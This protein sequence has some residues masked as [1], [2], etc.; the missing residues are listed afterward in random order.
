MAPSSVQMLDEVYSYARL[1]SFDEG[2][3]AERLTR[4]VEGLIASQATLA[5]LSAVD[6][7]LRAALAALQAFA[8]RAMRLRLDH[9]VDDRALPAATRK[10]FA[11]TV[12]GY[13]SDL[14]VLRERVREIVL[15]TS[16]MMAADVAD[17]V[18]GAAVLTLELLA[19]SS[20]VVF[21]LARGVAEAVLPHARAAA[22]DRALDDATRQRWSAARREL[23]ALLEQPER[24]AA[25]PLAE[26]LAAR[27]AELDEPEPEPERTRAELLELD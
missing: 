22:R 25:A 5:E 9:V 24:L 12:L 6:E 3:Y 27:P 11:S 15:R 18:V 4:E 20:A 1:E 13:A 10:V 19:R 21:T 17:A 7:H 14:G 26:R 16:P 2:G 8:G 23:E